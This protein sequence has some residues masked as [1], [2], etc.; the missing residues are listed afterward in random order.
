MKVLDATF[1]IDYLGG[2]NG[3][4]EYLLDREDETFLVPAPVLAEVL[5]GEGNVDGDLAGVRADLG[6][7]EVVEVDGSTADLAGEIAAEV[8]PEGPMLSG[9]GGLIAAV[10]R[11]TG[12]AVVSADRDLTHPEVERVVDVEE[13]R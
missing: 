7:A 8:G 11:E 10:G 6:W 9:H 2:H 13:Y 12:A 3:A 4:A 5:V 1:L